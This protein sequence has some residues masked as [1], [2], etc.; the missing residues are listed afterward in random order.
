MT[1]LLLL[2]KID[3][4]LVFDDILSK[5]CIV[6]LFM[7]CRDDILPKDQAPGVKREGAIPSAKESKVVRHSTE[8][9]VIP[10]NAGDD[11]EKVASPTGTGPME[12]DPDADGT[13]QE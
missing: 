10:P 6:D 2:Q 7:L 13:V 5:A 9:D 11:S 3:K 4:D 1:S 8:K 12:I